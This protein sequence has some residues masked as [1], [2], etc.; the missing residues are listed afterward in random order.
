VSPPVQDPLLVPHVTERRDPQADRPHSGELGPPTLGAPRW[1]AAG[2]T[3]DS[4][5][6]DRRLSLR[7]LLDQASQRG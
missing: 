4:G 1:A 3:T 5:R 2:L 7:R 6:R